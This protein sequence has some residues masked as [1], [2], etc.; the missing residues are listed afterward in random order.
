M[1]FAITVVDDNGP[2]KGRERQIDQT[3]TLP[4]AYYKAKQTSFEY[5]IARIRHITWAKPMGELKEIAIYVRGKR[6]R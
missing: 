1:A 4:Q 2:D 5:P 6:R 3:V